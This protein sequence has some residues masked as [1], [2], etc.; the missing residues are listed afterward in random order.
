VLDHLD[1]QV[2]VVVRGIPES[3][4][5]EDLK[6]HKE[7]Q[8]PKALRVQQEI[9]VHKE[10]PDHKDLKVDKVHLVTKGQEG[11]LG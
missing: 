11:L 7:I 5:P 1:H 3:L 9:L 2:T 8:V 10:A 6:A 4:V